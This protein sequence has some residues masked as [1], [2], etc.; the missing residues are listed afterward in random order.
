MHLGRNE[1]AFLDAG[2]LI[3]VGDHLAAELVS[4]NERGANAVLRPAIPVIDVKVG[5][6][7][8]GDLD[9]DQDIGPPKAW[10]FDFAH[11]SAWGSCR[12]DDSEHG[13]LHDEYLMNYRSNTKRMILA[14]GV[15]ICSAVSQG[16]VQRLTTKDTEPAHL[17]RG[18]PHSDLEGAVLYCSDFPRGMLRDFHSLDRRCLA[19]NNICP[20]WWA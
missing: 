18:T 16:K 6:A 20:M 3:A 11:F 1:I 14:L 9:F 7:D 8:R 2:H 12:L 4:G 13:G 17:S 15:L 5:S 10:N 19:R